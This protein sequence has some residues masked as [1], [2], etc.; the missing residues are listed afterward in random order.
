MRKRSDE[1]RLSEI[2][3]MFIDANMLIN[4]YID[5]IYNVRL[6]KNM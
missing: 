6:L 4:R 3:K 1:K 2:K 5:V